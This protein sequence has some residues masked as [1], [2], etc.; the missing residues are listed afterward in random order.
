MDNASAVCLYVPEIIDAKLNTTFD[1][2]CNEAEEFKLFG[3]VFFLPAI[4]DY[5]ASLLGG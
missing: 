4:V 3:L 5:A 1:T 2:I